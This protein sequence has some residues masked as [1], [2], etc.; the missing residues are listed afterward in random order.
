MCFRGFPR[1]RLYVHLIAASGESRLPN[2][3]ACPTGSFPSPAEQFFKAPA[4]EV[5]PCCHE[6]TNA[7]ESLDVSLFR[8]Q[9]RVRPKMRQ[10][11]GSQ[12]L[13]VPHFEIQGLIRPVRSNESASPY[14]LELIEQL[15]SVRVL[16]DRETRPH[17]PTEAVPL[18][19][20]KRNAETAFAVHESRNVGGQIHGMNQGRRFMESKE[21]TP[22]RDL[23]P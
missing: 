11:F 12:I 13:D 8:R 20:L 7:I 23:N 6:L 14:L 9:K 1:H 16:A 19:G 15:S 5:S 21:R 18:A 4:L 17:F 22:S 3:F 10:H 2:T